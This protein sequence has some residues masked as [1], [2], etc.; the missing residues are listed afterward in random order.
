MKFS[1]TWLR[2]WV[3][4]GLTREE[5]SDRLTMTGL[6]VESLEPVAEHFARVV[7]GKVLSVKKHEAADQLHICEVETGSGSPLVIVCGAANVKTGMKVPV[8]LVDAILPN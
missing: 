8:A 6:E 5:L 4:P 7:I 1:E 2:E 3:S